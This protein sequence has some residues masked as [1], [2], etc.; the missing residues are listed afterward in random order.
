M[1]TIN[2]KRKAAFHGEV[3]FKEITD[4][5]ILK[6]AKKVTVKDNFYIVGESETH[7]NDHR[8]AVKDKSKVEFYTRDGVLYMRN[9]ETVDVYCPNEG[10]HSTMQL[11]SGTWVIDKQQELDYL[12]QEMRNVV[13]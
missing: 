2:N 1:T 3:V 9:T 6:G 12:S 4:T 7:G 11:P 10:R 5:S 13:D 8:V